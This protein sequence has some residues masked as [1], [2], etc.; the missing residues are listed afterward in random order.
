MKKEDYT[1]IHEEL[2]DE[3]K[4]MAETYRLWSE[5]TSDDLYE[6]NMKMLFADAELLQIDADIHPKL[7]EMCEALKRAIIDKAESIRKANESEKLIGSIYMD[8]YAIDRAK[9]E[10]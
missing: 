6:A 5:N 2:L 9:R 1:T 7:K 8:L 4:D 10:A 3:F